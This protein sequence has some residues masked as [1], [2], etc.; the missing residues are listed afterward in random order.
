M[1]AIATNSEWIHISNKMDRKMD[2]R[3]KDI[4]TNGKCNIVTTS[5]LRGYYKKKSTFFTKDRQPCT[6][7]GHLTDTEDNA[8]VERPCERHSD[9]YFDSLVKETDSNEFSVPGADGREG[10]AILLRPR[11]TGSHG[12]D[13][14]TER[15]HPS[16]RYN[17]SVDNIVVEKSR[18]LE[19]INRCSKQHMDLNT[20][21]DMNWDLVDFEPWGLFSSVV[22]ACS[23]CGF[24]SA[25]TK[26]YEE[27]NTE[28]PG[29]K[30]AV[31][32]VRLQLLLQD[33]PIGPTELQLIF[34]AVGLRAGSLSGMQ[35]MS[36]K[37]S[38]ATEEV[39]DTD[40]IKWREHTKKVLAD[41]GINKYNEISAAFD[42]RYHGMFKA[43]S[44]TPGP[45]AAQA[46]ATCVETVT[47]QKKCI[48]IDHINKACP[49]GSRMKGKGVTVFCGTGGDAKHKGCTANQPSGRGIRECDMAERI[50]KDIL[51]TSDI[52]VT[53]LCTDSDATG[54]DAFSR[55]NKKSDKPLP[56]LTWYKDPS[57][58]SRNMKRHILDHNFSSGAFGLK[59]DGG[60][61][62]YKERLDCRKALAL[63]V[64]E[65]VSVT[66]QS[67]SKHYKGDF[68][69]MKKNTETLVNYIMK[70]YGGDHTSCQSAPLAQLT[71]CKGSVKSSRCWFAKSS[72]LRGQGISKLQLTGGDY[73]FLKSVIQM[74]LGEEALD[75][76]TRRET[77][78]R[79]ESINRAISKSCPKNRLFSRTSRGRVCSAIGRQNN[80]FRD[81]VHMKFRAMSC[82]LPPDSI[83]Y[84]IIQK[85]QRKRDLTLINQ[86]KTS[87]AKRRQSLLAERR[88]EYF[89]ERLKYSN[90]GEYHKY[91][92]DLAQK[93]KEAALDSID[94]SEPLPSTSLANQIEKAAGTSKHM[95]EA[96]KQA[97]KYTVGQ[98]RSQLRSRR[99]R[100]KSARRRIE[101]Q[102]AARRIGSRRTRCIRLEHS[103]GAILT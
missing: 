5:K 57:H 27:V 60:G 7:K 102:N 91:Q 80:S 20:C 98:V 35:K 73:E 77:T 84:K 18:L 65:R 72:S 12:V 101:D 24:R 42:V 22:L 75:F 47:P 71:G 48:A 78:S 44:K 92:L 50:A 34:A 49:K 69:K 85:Y 40:M 88:K 38:D 26:L 9:T 63:D 36:Y 67:A 37:A 39:A 79:C 21:K 10:S 66:L 53:H 55:V 1:D 99:R 95:K 31:G 86:K 62:N 23:S 17:V 96:L 46:T 93:A 43:S 97:K 16:G 3:S 81:F 13:V 8:P 54:R 45:G 61:W 74:K 59:P 52:A 11:R 15:G 30:P 64:P 19:L 4:A 51:A 100:S 103:Y 94:V 33:M 41:R 83:G 2:T 32:N 6:T 68:T 90:E 28:G 56:P 14:S 76:F 82:S 87:A 89:T 25:R 70:C 29:R 58:V